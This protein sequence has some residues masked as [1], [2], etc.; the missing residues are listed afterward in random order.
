MSGA[1]VRVRFAPAPTGMLHV[2]GARTA[3]FNFLFA[4]QRGGAFVLRCEDT[5]AG[6]SSREA[7]AQMESELRWLGL[8]W[9]EGADI[10]G[11]FRPYRQS[12]RR[13]H[14]GWAAAKLI[15]IDA[16]Y[17]CYCTA[18]ELEA[19]RVAAEAR[20]LAP[21][22]SGKCR[23]LSKAQQDELAAQGRKPALRFSMP[24][25]DIYV[26]D[27]I[28]GS[29]HFPAGAIG[30]F[31]VVKSDGVPAYNFAAVIDDSSMEITH[32]IRGDEH[33]PNTPRQVALY[34]AL[35]LPLPL[36]A[37]VSMILAPDHQ[38][39][40]K[41]HGA[42]AVSEYRELGYLGPALINYLAL[43]GW[44]P[45]DDRELFTLA[46]LIESFS[47]ERV[48]KSP[49]VFD[50]AKLKWFNAH[51]LRALPEPQRRALFADWLRR[52]PQFAGSAELQD[53]TWLALLTSAISDHVEVLGDVPREAAGLLAGA[54]AAA[55]MWD[56]RALGVLRQGKTPQLLH[57]LLAVAHSCGDD[58]RAFAAAT[59]KEALAALGART[60]VKGRE[61]YRPLR[62]AVTG[63]EHG[64]ELPLLLPLLGPR[65]VAQRLGLA[66]QQFKTGQER[67]APG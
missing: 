67:F 29:V 44:S 35:E 47:L 17:P 3:L 36:F 10:G 53:E 61:L 51:Y 43:L 62:I 16:A 8:D 52:S 20:G 34:E 9:D 2:G 66:L 60:G 39:L 15:E 42:T 12:E 21:R 40:S 56:A 65:R 49:A 64:I 27:L 5:D 31:V 23:T 19:Q 13:E 26:E 38:K 25:R 1:P 6:R 33:L 22:Y 63:Q 55:G 59:S 41:R 30:D 14:Y 45:G 4:R 32:V 28:R 46:Q 54:P 24:Q 11:P 7:E 57:E 48:S 18:E 58:R 37:H 50:L